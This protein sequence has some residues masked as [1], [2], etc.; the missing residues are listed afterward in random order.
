MTRSG[1][2]VVAD[3]S[4]ATERVTILRNLTLIHRLIC[5]AAYRTLTDDHVITVTTVDRRRAKSNEVEQKSGNVAKQRPKCSL[6][7]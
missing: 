1:E 6:K 5:T 7:K 2:W 3:Q 4:S